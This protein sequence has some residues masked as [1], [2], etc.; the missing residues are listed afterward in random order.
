MRIRST[1]GLKGF[2][3]DLDYAHRLKSN[4]SDVQEQSPCITGTAPFMALELLQGPDTRTYHT[5]RHDL[6]SF[7]YVVIWLCIVDPYTTLNSWVQCLSNPALA[8]KKK[9]DITEFFE[10]RILGNFRGQFSS[11]KTLV[12]RLRDILFLGHLDSKGLEALKALRKS[13]A[14]DAFRKNYELG[15]PAGNDAR[16]GIY[17]SIIRTFDDCIAKLAR[18]EAEETSG[19]EWECV[20]QGT[21]TVG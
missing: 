4:L 11:L 3:I 21:T 5:W 18:S 2:L 9:E 1:S 19:D 13:E 6:E 12:S 10:E 17:D 16:C 14:R 20:E 15:T 8:P 7:F